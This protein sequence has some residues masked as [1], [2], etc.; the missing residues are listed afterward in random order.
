M[1]TQD[2]NYCTFPFKSSNGTLYRDAC[3]QAGKNDP[4]W[5]VVKNNE[6]KERKTRCR[7]YDGK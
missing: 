7:A 2:Q 4:G 5:C 3:V 1:R 6:G